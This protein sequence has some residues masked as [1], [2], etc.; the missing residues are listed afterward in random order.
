MPVTASVT[1]LVYHTKEG[2]LNHKY[3]CTHIHIFL[4]L[5]FS[6]SLSLSLKHT[7]THTNTNTHIHT[8]SETTHNIQAITCGLGAFAMHTQVKYIFC[9]SLDKLEHEQ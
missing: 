4:S 1:E 8:H 6:L 2:A 3:S 7:L 5:S 9:P